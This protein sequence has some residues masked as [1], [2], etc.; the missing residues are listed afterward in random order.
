MLTNPP[1]LLTDKDRA[2]QLKAIMRTFRRLFDPT[3]W[4]D[5]ET[6]ERGFEDEYITAYSALARLK[7]RVHVHDADWP[8]VE[9]DPKSGLTERPAS[10]CNFSA[11]TA[12]ASTIKAWN[13]YRSPARNPRAERAG[14]FG[15]FDRSCSNPCATSASA[16]ASLVAFGFPRM[17]LPISVKDIA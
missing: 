15:S 7:G 3:R 6:F 16:T 9:G 12:T 8:W 2:T 1:T 17:A 5:P 10:R 4:S 13:R 14:R 11:V